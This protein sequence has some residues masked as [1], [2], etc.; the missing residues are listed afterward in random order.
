MFN[1]VLQTNSTSYYLL[2]LQVKKLI[3]PLIIPGWELCVDGSD[4]SH[5][6]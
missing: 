1:V 4:A 6:T 3:S 2:M 5:R